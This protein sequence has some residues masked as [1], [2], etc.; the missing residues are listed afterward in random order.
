MAVLHLFNVTPASTFDTVVC[1]GEV[2]FYLWSSASPSHKRL[3]NSAPLHSIQTH[4]AFEQSWAHCSDE[5]QN[6]KPHVDLLLVFYALVN[7]NPS[8]RAKKRQIAP[9]T[10]LRSDD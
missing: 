3:L 7:K 4:I 9:F 2:S 1:F 5:I 8:E 10:P 6:N